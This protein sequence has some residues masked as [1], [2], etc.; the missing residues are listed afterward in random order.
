LA[1]ITALLAG[2]LPVIK[3]VTSL[4]HAIHSVIS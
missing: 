2:A 4:V 1:L 3:A